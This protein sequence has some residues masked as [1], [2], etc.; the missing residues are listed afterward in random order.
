[1][2]KEELRERAKELMDSYQEPETYN[3]WEIEE[4]WKSKRYYLLRE[5]VNEENDLD[6]F[7]ML[8][9]VLQTLFIGRTKVAQDELDLA[10]FHDPDG[11]WLKAARDPGFGGPMYLQRAQSSGTYARQLWCLRMWQSHTGR[12]I[13]GL[14]EIYEF[15]G[16]YGVMPVVCRRMG[17]EGQYNIFDFPELVLLQDYYLSNVGMSDGVHSSSVYMGRDFVDLV[18]GIYSFSESPI[19]DRDDFIDTIHAGSYM[20]AIQPDWNDVDNREW[21]NK[22]MDKAGGRWSSVPMKPDGYA[23][24]IGDG[25]WEGV[26]VDNWEGWEKKE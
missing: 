3:G 7:L 1:M 17:F 4:F 20:I 6:K 8:P 9:T 24:Y 18:I 22:L 16:G 25:C 13:S 10:L 19:G 23:L 15:G 2:T 5:I 26:E 14:N 12:E 21:M 11:S